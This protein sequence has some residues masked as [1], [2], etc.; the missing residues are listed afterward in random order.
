MPHL[1]AG[2]AARQLA[3]H[4]HQAAEVARNQY[5]SVTRRARVGLPR[6]LGL[7]AISLLAA[8]FSA[9]RETA[10]PLAAT[11]DLVTAAALPPS[12][13]RP[14]LEDRVVWLLDLFAALDERQAR[15][16]SVSRAVES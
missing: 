8:P 1:G 3:G 4:V 7:A 12:P 13:R 11:L 9:S 16:A 6:K 5:D 10:P 2:A 14:W 15:G